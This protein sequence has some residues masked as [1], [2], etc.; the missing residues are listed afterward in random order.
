MLLMRNS[1]MT[2]C[3]GD[4]MNLELN[5]VIITQISRNISGYTPKE[6]NGTQSVTHTGV[7]PSGELLM[8]LNIMCLL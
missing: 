6:W 5:V 7:E 3:S 4:R 2:A 8:K 1:T